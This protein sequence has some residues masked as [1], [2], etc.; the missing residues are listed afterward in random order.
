VT[1]TQDRAAPT[2][3][4]GASPR[5]RAD[6]VKKWLVDHGASSGDQI[7]TKGFGKTQPIADNKTEKGASRIGE[8]RS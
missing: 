8:P 5:E 7:T 6:A 4:T 3:T 1:A 2:S